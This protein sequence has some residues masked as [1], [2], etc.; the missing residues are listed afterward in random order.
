[1]INSVI[2]FNYDGKVYATDE[3]RMLAEMKDF[4][5]E[6]GSLDTHSYEELFYGE[7]AKSFS[8]YWTN[9]SLPGCSECAFQPYCGADPVF[10]YATQ[11]TLAG[12]RPTSSFCERNMTIIKHLFLLME[13]DDRIKNIFR[14]WITGKN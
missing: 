2:V 6:L 1:M 7:K 3:A 14:T 5:F 11:G 13:K 4:T 8:D 9:E 10:N 12:H